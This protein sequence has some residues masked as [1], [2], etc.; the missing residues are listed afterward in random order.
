MDMLTLDAAT[1]SVKDDT[2]FRQ[3]CEK[4]IRTRERSAETFRN[5]GFTVLP[6]QTN[7]LLVTRPDK[8]AKELFGKLKEQKIFVRYFNQP[9]VDNHLRVTVGTDEEMDKLFT[10]LRALF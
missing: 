7:F 8:S 6:S 9:R 10:A 1:A 3:T 2:Y 5:M 4:V